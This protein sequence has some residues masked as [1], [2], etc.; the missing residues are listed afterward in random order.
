MAVWNEAIAIIAFMKIPPELGLNRPAT[1]FDEV[2][3]LISQLSAANASSADSRDTDGSRVAEQ[4][5]KIIA[6]LAQQLA[7]LATIGWKMQKRVIDAESGDI[8]DNFDASDGRKLGRDVQSL[9]S[10]LS[11]MGITIRDRTGQS[12]D[13]GMP[14]KVIDAKPQPG[15]SKERVTETLRPTVTWTTH[16]FKEAMIQ[17]GEVI[18]QTPEA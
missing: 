9:L 18:I 17:K 12:F 7:S 15:I 16:F 13:Y 14:E 1:G 5:N 11:D 8:R 4:A 3:K 2:L 6:G 10:L